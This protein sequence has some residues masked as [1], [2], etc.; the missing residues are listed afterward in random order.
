VGIRWEAWGEA[1]FERA[2]REAKPALLVLTAR[3]CHACHRMDEDTWDDPGVAALVERVAVPVKVDADARPDVYSRYHLG[4]L[5]SVALLD[6]DGEFI[7]GATFLTVAELHGFLDGAMADWR[8][9]RRPAKR[10]TPA[11]AAPV[12]LVDTVVARLV[13]RADREHG[14]FG[15]AP[16]LPEVEAVTLLLRRWRGTREAALERIVR[17]S[18]DAVLLHLGDPRDG[19]VFRYAAGA[20]W[21]G[22]HTEKLALDQALLARLLLEAGAALPEP[23]YVAAARGILAHARH[24]L[25]DPEGRVFSSVAADPEYYARSSGDGLEVPGDAAAMRDEPWEPLPA[26][27][28]RRFADGSAA[29]IAASSLAL[30]VT[31]EELGFSPE[32]RAGTVAGALPHWLDEPGGVRGLLRDHALGLT[33]ALA[34][35]RVTGDCATLEWG[36]RAAACAIEQLWDEEESAFR[37]E[38]A[39]AA[40]EVALPPM[41]PLLGN[42]EMAVALA[43]LAGHTG[44]AE[45]AR[46]AERA[47]AALGARAALSP[48]GPA[49][50]LAALRLADR[51]SEVDL[52]GN[53]EDPRTRALARAAVAALGPTVI[54]RWTGTG[55]PALTLCARDLCLPPIADPRHLL[56]ALMQVGLAPHGILALWSSPGPHEEGRAS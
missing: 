40:G 12:D 2:R 18:I 20:D 7:R 5:P 4:G 38:P 54:V 11:R 23:R 55:A 49:L 33:A 16:K 51:P 34:E 56:E 45:Y 53:A 22:A 17:A 6:A 3:W 10:A 30:A 32:Y 13:K 28:T 48:A 9:G 1:A 50:A 24:R 8:A 27:D 47:V 37:A 21:S 19:G 44:R 52:D 39:S 41:L 42:G 15:V 43:D 36:E 14:G 26:V 25:A 35:Y 46:Y 29:M 31:G